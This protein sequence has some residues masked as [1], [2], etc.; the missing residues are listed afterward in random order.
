MTI[1]D[2]YTALYPFATKRQIEYLDAVREH[3]S[4]RAAGIALGLGNDVLSKAIRSL[5]AK[6]ALSGIAPGHFESG[7]APGFLMGKVT[8]QRGADGMVERTWERQ[9]PDEARSL[10]ILTSSIN[11]IIEDA[12][13][14]MPP[15]AAPKQHDADLLTVVPMG[16]PHFGMLA[17]AREVGED[18]NLKI[19]EE[20][21]F[22]AVDWLSS[23]TPSSKVA[24]LLNLGDFFHADNSSNRTPQSGNPLD[25]DGRF[26]LIAE[27][28][29]RAMVR[30]IRRLLEK[31][32][33]VIVR[34]NRGNH[35]PH[36]AFMLSLALSGMFSNE[37]R[38]QVELEPSSFYYHRFG[39][40][41]I[42]STHGD[43]T[44]L[45]D[46][47]MIMATD[48][49]QDWADAEERVWHCGHFHHDQVKDYIGCR[50]E[51]HRTLAAN[52]SW[53]RHEGYR[54]YKDMKAI[55]YDRTLGEVDRIRCG[56]LVLKELKK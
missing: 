20:V 19:A 39:V 32:E 46:L 54:S 48:A 51:T 41:L 56:S 14:V 9:S 45:A 33:K 25:V 8:I 31:H 16:D 18:F 42:G 21:T 7:T 6:A 36:Q 10:E 40:T 22:A 27:V 2:K 35:D 47:P 23:R 52:D 1:H 13:G 15:V 5:R 3:G 26:P 37:P 43:G 53:H 24:L 28:G 44:K 30:C 55:I 34:N 29:F 50:V 17:W 11:A 38:V 12:R 4:E 49:K